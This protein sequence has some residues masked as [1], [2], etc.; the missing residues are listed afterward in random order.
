MSVIF[1]LYLQGT[2][3]AMIGLLPSLFVVQ[4][5]NYVPSLFD[6][7]ILIYGI[8]NVVFFLKMI[9]HYR[10]PMNVAFD[11]CVNDLLNLAL[12][13]KTTYNMVNIIIFV[14]IWLMLLALNISRIIITI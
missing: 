7:F 4:K 11:K 5:M 13:F 2:I 3:L 10:S 9:S 12:R 6:L 1:N 14:V 8:I